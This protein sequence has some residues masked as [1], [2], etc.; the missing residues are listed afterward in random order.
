MQLRKFAAVGLI[1]ALSLGLVAGI[2]Q[3]QGSSDQPVSV[4]FTNVCQQRLLTIQQVVLARGASTDIT[5]T[6]LEV[7]P[8]ETQTL[9][10]D[11]DF[12]PARLA[13]GGRIG[14]QEFSFTVESLPL[15]QTFTP[16]AADGCVEV[17]VEAPGGRQELPPEED[18]PIEQ[19][20]SL[21][22]VQQILASRG[23]QAERIEGSRSNPK[24]GGVDDPMFLRG[25]APSSFQLVWVTSGA[26]QLR[27]T[28]TWDD[29]SVDLDL[30]V[31]GAGGACLQLNGPGVLSELCDRPAE[32][33]HGPVGG[34]VSG[35]AFAVL[36]VN[37]SSSSQSYVL[38]LSP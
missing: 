28:I 38:S 18:K 9:N 12:T 30:M 13:V 32:P 34:P 25:I 16:D 11:L 7:P 17:L 10:K 5:V 26:G 1:V 27:S 36:I 8:G 20:Q 37:W 4:S 24:L 35:S 31:F 23:I 33:G 15:N 22:Q 19:G 14:Q 6:S 21:Q 3:T 2:G 29:P